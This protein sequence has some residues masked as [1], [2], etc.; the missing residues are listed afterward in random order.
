MVSAGGL[1]TSLAVVHGRVLTAGEWLI[2]RG[3][4]GTIARAFTD[5]SFHGETNRRRGA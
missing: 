4:N 3:S 5:L 2:Q 1:D